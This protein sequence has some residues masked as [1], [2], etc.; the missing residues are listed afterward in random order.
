[1]ANDICNLRL[2]RLDG[3]Q[4]NQNRFSRILNSQQ[5]D[6]F[7]PYPSPL[8]GG[9]GKDCD[10]FCNQYIIR[11]PNT[12][13]GGQYIIRNPQSIGDGTGGQYT[14]RAPNAT[15]MIPNGMQPAPQK[16]PKTIVQPNIFRFWNGQWGFILL[17]WNCNPDDQISWQLCPLNT[18]DPQPDRKIC[19][20]NITLVR[21]GGITYDFNNLTAIQAYGVTKQLKGLGRLIYHY[22]YC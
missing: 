21:P 8:D 1:M 16:P 10:L 22:N 2:S 17:I 6:Y 12:S 13:G 3:E 7:R 9:G 19:S 14:T 11:I 4:Y 15:I 18:D 20:V 5:Y